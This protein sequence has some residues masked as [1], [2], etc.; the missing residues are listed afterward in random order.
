MRDIGESDRK[1]E[2]ARLKKRLR[3]QNPET[4]ASGARLGSAAPGT[5]GGIAPDEVKAPSKKELKKGAAAARIAEASS[6]ASANQTLNTLMGGFGGRKKG[7]Q[8]SWMTGGGSG[9]N[10]PSRLN[11]P[12]TPGSAAAATNVKAAQERPTQDPKTQWGK[13]RE[14]VMGKNIQLRDWVTVLEMD[15]TDVKSIQDAYM[16]LDTSGAK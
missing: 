15:R 4:P 6:T 10:T 13:W 3:R 11:T 1:V 8:Y 5:P 12:G 16:K 7:K 14:N 9:A 2:D